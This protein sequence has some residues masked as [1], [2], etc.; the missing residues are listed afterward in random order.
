[1]RPNHS[2]LSP[3]KL[4]KLPL[5]AFL[6]YALLLGL[7]MS[8]CAAQTRLNSSQVAPLKGD[9]QGSFATNRLRDINSAA[10]HGN[11]TTNGVASAI[12]D[13]GI[14]I[15]CSI[16]VPPSYGT[17]EPVPGYRLTTATP[18]QTATTP[19]NIAIFD[20]RYGDARMLVNYAGY[21]SGQTL[22]PTGW[23]YNYYLP[24]LQNELLS[25]FYLRQ[26]SVDGGHNQSSA[27]LNYTDK[28]A[29]TT[30]QATDVSHTPGQHEGLLVGG[31]MTSIG[32]V[33]PIDNLVSCSGG[34]TTEGDQGCQA[35]SNIVAQ[36]TV[37]YSG[38][39]SGAPTTGAT[40][41]SV[42]PTQG[43]NTQGASR[44]LVKTNAG[45]IAAGTV[46]QIATN[47]GDAVITG[48]GHSVAGIDRH[49]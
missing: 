26:W 13:C 30:V 39:L 23:L 41:L 7:S 20:H 31:Q 49:R 35:Q 37:E 4:C 14:T 18:A 33:I 21:P 38:T 15:T 29:W 5:G 6:I 36:R 16:L 3:A 25:S 11:G 8:D 34:L 24:S 47:Y 46:S 48:V 9:A 45:T 43:A 19:G 1:M 42:A 40:S 32:N 22:A 28:T 2:A 17:L 12:N 44:F 10:D 27:A